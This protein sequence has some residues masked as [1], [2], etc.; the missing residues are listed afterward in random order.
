MTSPANN[1]DIPRTMTLAFNKKPNENHVTLVEQM[2]IIKAW[3]KLL[4]TKAQSAEPEENHQQV[5][6]VIPFNIIS[7][8]LV[9]KRIAEDK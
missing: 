1:I 2:D 9:K 6:M 3:W 8:F 7:D 4:Q 5:L